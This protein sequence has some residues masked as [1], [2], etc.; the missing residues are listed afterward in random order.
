MMIII[1]EKSCFN[2]IL[3]L[4]PKGRGFGNEVQ[5]W[6]PLLRS[7]EMSVCH[8]AFTGKRL[9]WLYRGFASY[10]PTMLARSH[11]KWCNL[12]HARTCVLPHVLCSKTIQA[13]RFLMVLAWLYFCDH[14][15]LWASYPRQAC[16]RLVL[17]IK[18]DIEPAKGWHVG[19]CKG[20]LLATAMRKNMWRVPEFWDGVETFNIISPWVYPG[21]AAYINNINFY[22]A[23]LK[24]CELKY[25][26][27]FPLL[28]ISKWCNQEKAYMVPSWL[29]CFA[30]ILLIVHHSYDD[31]R[32]YHMLPVLAEICTSPLSTTCA[33]H[34]HDATRKRLY[35]CLMVSFLVSTQ[36]YV[37]IR[38]NM[39]HAERCT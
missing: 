8:A 4:R 1:K 11:S 26:R 22:V 28:T 2:W 5:E 21:L 20:R 19:T 35:G 37:G 3:I 12:A 38:P 23:H 27:K 7:I 29:Y 36:K 10:E 16:W 31:L 33:V 34:Q 39:P 18:N 24:C 32:C 9:T 14:F 6:V 13:V 30:R 25:A 17:C 15:T